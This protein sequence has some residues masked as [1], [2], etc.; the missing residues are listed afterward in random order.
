MAYGG[1]R[2]GGKSFWGL[3]QVVAD[4]CRRFPGL[5]FL[6][7]RKVG[8]AAREAIQDLRMAVLEHVPHTYKVQEGRIVLANGSSVILGHFQYEKDVDN[9]LGLEYDGALIE[10]ATQLSTGKVK[11]IGTCVRTS[12][13]GWRPRIYYTTNPGGIGHGW[14][15]S[16]FIAPM[17]AGNETST[18][19]IQ[20]TVRD[21][22]AVNPEY[23]A[24]L[25]NLTGWQRKA[26]LEGDWD[27]AAGQFFT[28]F[29]HDDVVKELGP[30]PPHWRVWLG[31]DYGYTHYTSAHLL[32]LSGDG[33]L[34]AVDEHAERGWLPEQ[35]VAAI[36]SMLARHGRTVGDL[37]A[38]CAGW[39]CFNR[40]RN[41]RSIA[42]DYAM[43]GLAL[44]RA[45]A[46]RV[47]G[48]AEVLRR[49]GSPEADPPRAPTMSIDPRCARLIECLPSLQRD[50]HRP[51]DVLKVDTDDDGIGGDDFYDSFRYSCMYVAVDRTLRDGGDPFG[52]RRW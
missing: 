2:G 32:A 14:F 37:E 48:A 38:V 23:R 52:G 3:S 43:L 47:N 35:H 22:P 45:D 1:A 6:Y 40:D 44:D 11:A 28:N 12:K 15:K 10:E 17:R 51:E 50:P 5:K 36:G 29:R 13:P 8:Y 9:Y 16:R 18:R 30:L 33:H 31:F 34:W 7:L 26:W 25:E 39:D 46:D 21:N 41:G 19:F 20:A 24:T 4:D 42:D 27:L 49:L